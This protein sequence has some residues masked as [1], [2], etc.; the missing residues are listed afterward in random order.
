MDESKSATALF[1]APRPKRTGEARERATCTGTAARATA[2]MN[3]N[4]GPGTAAPAAR[5]GHDGTR[6]CGGE[7]TL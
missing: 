4:A 5:A 6:S 7:D 2:Q 3:Q 1:G